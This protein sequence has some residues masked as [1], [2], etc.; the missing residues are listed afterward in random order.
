MSVVDNTF[1][2]PIVARPL[3]MGATVVV[4]SATKYLSGHADLLMGVAV[5]RDAAIAERLV[6][7]RS[8][9]GAVPGAVEA[10][11]ALR[12]LRTLQLRMER[13]QAS[14]AVLADR[15][16]RHPRVAEVHYPGCGAMVSVVLTRRRR[17]RGPSVQRDAVVGE[18]H[19][20]RR[21]RV[22]PGT[23]PALAGREP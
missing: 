2:T 11:L 4:H 16:G 19:E 18:R 8:L 1:N 6:S 10:W 23:T 20:P 7:H 5:A 21:C 13:A 14:A 12:G 9:Q 17:R 3:E 22:E 15:L